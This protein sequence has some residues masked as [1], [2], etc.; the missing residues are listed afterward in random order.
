VSAAT[1]S[2]SHGELGNK[3]DP[4]PPLLSLRLSGSVRLPRL[5]H[6]PGPIH[7]ILRDENNNFFYSDEINH[8][9]VSLNPVGNIRWHISKQGNGSAEFR[10]PKGLDLGWI[11]IKGARTNCLGV[12]DS[13][14]RRVQFFDRDGSYLTSWN[15]VGEES[16]KDV[17]DIRFIGVPDGSKAEL[18]YWLILDRGHHSLFGVNISGELMFQIGRAFP[19][20]LESHWPLPSDSTQLQ[21]APLEMIHNC[22][23][24][25]PLFMPARIF[26]STGEALFIWEP[27]LN[28]LKHAALGNMLP[29]LIDPPS[30]TE[31]VGADEHGLLCFNRDAGSLGSYDSDGKTWRLAEIQG[32]PVPSGRSTKEIWSQD[33]SSLRHWICDFEGQ[34]ADGS[35][36]RCPWVLSA[37]PDELA[38]G[39]YSGI[40]GNYLERLRAIT[41]DLRRSSNAALES[42]TDTWTDPTSVDKARKHLALLTKALTVVLSEL[43]GFTHSIFVGLLRIQTLQSNFPGTENQRY[44]SKELDRIRTATKPEEDLFEEMLSF[45]DDWF[46]ARLAKADTR[47]S[48]AILLQEYHEGLMH[49]VRELANWLW[50]IPFFDSARTVPEKSRTLG[51]NQAS[52]KC[53]ASGIVRSLPRSN[54]SSAFLREIDRILVSDHAD[55]GPVWPAAIC[56]QP[57]LGFWV[58]LNSSGQLLNL[59]DQGKVLGVVNL[60]SASNH[61]HSLAIDDSGRIWISLASNNRIGIYD[62]NTGQMRS[63]EDLAG[64]ELGLKY[65]MGVYSASDR[66]MLIADTQNNRIMVASTGGLVAPLLDQEGK[67]L[68]QL[69]HPV[70]FC[71]TKDRTEFWVVESKNHRL[72]RFSLNG[73]ALQQ[74]GK[75]GLGKG[76]LVQPE[77]A[78][79]FDDGTFVTSQRVCVN[80]LKLFTREGDEL[81]TVHLD[82]SPGG[83]LAHDSLLLVC[84]GFGNHIRVYERT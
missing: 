50:W 68:G 23:P 12:C 73:M 74:I 2:A 54:G 56:Y 84:E 48:Q 78:T 5:E 40:A 36:E 63:L 27:R 28:R 82:Y 14:N 80:S 15:K 8:S 39:I 79:I 18:S 53:I 58:T 77:S 1:A 9:V 46:L 6:D 13:W 10:Y 17:V 42:T 66:Q 67:R 47:E 51:S 26:G 7:T 81:E 43:R 70:A 31:W 4:A 32:T 38:V 64:I 20:N 19:D 60:P 62:P 61:P 83:V 57:T 45:R 35:G 76:C 34:E 59:S 75:A 25:D 3:T 49:V 69:R 41:A 29:I 44:L 16:L 11:E 71:G 37:L 72:Q 65:P 55:S 24:Y 21:V 30:G 22:L 33:G 52:P